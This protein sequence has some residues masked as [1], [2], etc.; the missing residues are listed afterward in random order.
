M[1]I[2]IFGSAEDLHSQ[3]LIAAVK[4]A[5]SEP[6]LIDYAALEYGWPISADGDRL[7][8]RG[9]R[10]DDLA[11][12]ILRFIPAPAAPALER[13]GRLELYEDW[14]AAFMQSRER[15]ALYMSWLLQLEDRGVPVVNPPHAGSVH[16]Y[17]PFQLDVLRRAGAQVPRTLISNDPEAIR[18]FRAELKDVI[19]KPV[20]G[21]AI[22]RPLD[23]EAMARLDLVTRSPVIFQERVRGDD[24]RVM[25]VG[26]RIISSVAIITPEQRLDFRADP[27][28]SG[29][30]ATYREVP[31]PEHVQRQCVAA[32]RVCKLEF[33]GIDI[34]HQGDDWVF[35]ELNSS[36]AYL[37]V[38][39][40]MGHPI[41]AQLVQHVLSL[42]RR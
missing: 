20:M 12:A 24:L 25:L 10:A 16:Q 2:G 33:A 30:T 13:A 35:L 3:A 11:G 28:Y 6:M 41:T 22:T 26:D 31:L 40:K 42:A 18:R 7:L 39:R 19:F 37:D 15:A 38:E 34:K 14:Y 1:K 8:Y 32:A 9:Q 4:A 5:G 23:E 36:P 17:K 21:G 27:A 29:G